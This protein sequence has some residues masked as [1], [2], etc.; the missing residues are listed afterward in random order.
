MFLV[1]PYSYRLPG[2]RSLGT[3]PVLLSLLSFVSFLSF[4][5]SPCWGGG[6][7]SHNAP[8]EKKK[9]NLSKVLKG[10][11]LSDEVLL[12]K[13]ADVCFQYGGK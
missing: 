1:A 6:R 7:G 12:D 10:K 2:T 4:F 11:K 5:L 8:I 13:L 3:H 9:T